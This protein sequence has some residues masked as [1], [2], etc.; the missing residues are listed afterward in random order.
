MQRK[1]N[2]HGEYA[3]VAYRQNIW[4]QTCGYFGINGNVSTLWSLCVVWIVIFKEYEVESAIILYT[5]HRGREL[6]TWDPI[7]VR[8]REQKFKD[9][10]HHLTNIYRK[11]FGVAWKVRFLGHSSAVVV[12]LGQRCIEVVPHLL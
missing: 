8:Q 12:K 9:T 4:S 5:L 11:V 3:F 10:V 2:V 1:I 7:V 6:G